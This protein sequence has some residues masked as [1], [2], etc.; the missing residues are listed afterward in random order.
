[1]TQQVPRSISTRADSR[2]TWGRTRAWIC[3]HTPADTKGRAPL[4]I[5]LSETRSSMPETQILSQQQGQGLQ[6]DAIR[7]FIWL[8]P[9]SQSFR[10]SLSHIHSND[11]LIFC[12]FWKHFTSATS[13]LWATPIPQR[14]AFLPLRMALKSS[15]PSRGLTCLGSGR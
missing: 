3:I 1:M 9:R 12:G 8:E 10:K 11:T 4:F 5:G 15:H 2:V 13:G 6:H 7:S 14:M